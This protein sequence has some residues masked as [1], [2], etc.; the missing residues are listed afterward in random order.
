MLVKHGRADST[1]HK[2]VHLGRQYSWDHS[3]GENVPTGTILQ[4]SLLYDHPLRT[5]EIEVTIVQFYNN[6]V[7]NLRYINKIY[8]EIGSASNQKNSSSR[9]VTNPYNYT[10]I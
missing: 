1:S 7:D 5:R 4:T 8:F 3:D 2:I 9:T 10:D 6:I